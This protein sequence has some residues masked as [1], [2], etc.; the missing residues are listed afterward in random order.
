VDP[1]LANKA[2]KILK[3]GLQIDEIYDWREVAWKTA[4]S[5]LGG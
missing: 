4:K 1:K 3:I 5:K 2:G